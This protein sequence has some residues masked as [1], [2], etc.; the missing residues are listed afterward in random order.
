MEYVYIFFLIL[1]ISFCCLKYFD[2]FI[3]KRRILWCIAIAVCACAGNY[4]RFHYFIQLALRDICIYGMIRNSMNEDRNIEIIAMILLME[5]IAKCSYFGL[6]LIVPLLLHVSIADAVLFHCEGLKIITLLIVFIF[7]MKYYHSSSFLKVR[8]D[9][10]TYAFVAACSVISLYGL[11]MI[12]WLGHQL[13]EYQLYF[14]LLSFVYV[15]IFNIMIYIYH[16]KQTQKEMT[17][18]IALEQLHILKQEKD[19]ISV[20]R[21]MIDDIRHDLNYFQSMVNAETKKQISKTID[22]IDD[23]HQQFIFHDYL[24]NNFIY[25]M[26]SEMKENQKDLKLIITNTKISIDLS[27]YN[28]LISVMKHVIEH[29]SNSYIQFSLQRFEEMT[30]FEFTYFP[31]KKQNQIPSLFSDNKISYSVKQITSI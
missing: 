10:I 12:P 18:Q 3:D 14:L 19:M 5:T 31:D 30:V 26:K 25:R 21:K 13:E 11:D 28:Q 7:L 9:Y 16:N 17:N 15:V 1:F 23:Y 29:S 24:L 8:C 4:F 22:K 2:V 6:V 27:I 20:Q